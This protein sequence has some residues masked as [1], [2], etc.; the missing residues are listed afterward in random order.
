MKDVIFRGSSGRI[1]RFS[2]HRPDE[3]FPV[4][5]A[6]YCFAR[7][8]AGGRGWAPVFLSRTANLKARLDGHERWADARL[9]GATH[10]LIHKREERD[11]REFVEADLLN[12]LKPVLN[13]PVLEAEPA[14]AKERFV[15]RPRLVW[16]A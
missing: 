13:A 1:H 5:A 4:S 3:D 9:L 6:V 12:S 2:L 10:I 8:V 16:A 14:E 11:A 15:G 7:P